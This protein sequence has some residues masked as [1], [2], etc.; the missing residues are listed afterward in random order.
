MKDE[1][2]FPE[3]KSEQDRFAIY[4]SSDYN[5]THVVAKVWSEGGLTKREY[6]AGLAMQGLAATR[7]VDIY[8]RQLQSG[9][10]ELLATLAVQQADALIEE[11]NKTKTEGTK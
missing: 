6:F 11:L 4:D 3:V 5:Y 8:N 7:L 10:A 9:Q 2:A 1:P